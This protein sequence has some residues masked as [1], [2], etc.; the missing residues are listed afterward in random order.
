MRQVPLYLIYTG[1]TYSSLSLSLGLWQKVPRKPWALCCRCWTYLLLSM[2]SL[3]LLVLRISTSTYS[4]Y[5]TSNTPRHQPH[6]QPPKT[7]I[8]FRDPSL[9]YVL[10]LAR[11][12]CNNH[13]SLSPA[14]MFSNPQMFNR[15]LSLLISLPFVSLT[16]ATS[17]TT[18]C[19]FQES[20]MNKSAPYSYR[21]I[22]LILLAC[23]IRNTKKFLVQFNTGRIAACR[24]TGNDTHEDCSECV[25]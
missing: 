20:P 15:R 21:Y 5:F 24:T 14:R 16:S 19:S 2:I 22:F 25:I 11:S 23:H 8:S 10:P 13:L 6:N 9:S 3:G 18:M 7:E 17:Q 1:Q 12:P 4:Q